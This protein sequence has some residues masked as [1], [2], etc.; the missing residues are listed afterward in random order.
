M[1]PV[2]TSAYDLPVRSYHHG[3][4]RAS[5]VEAGVQ[6][7]RASGPDGVVLREAARRTGVSH[8]AAY[9][10]FA[11]RK[12]LLS[13]I[14]TV[15]MQ[16]LGDAMRRE[17]DRV[18]GAEAR[19]R[20]VGRAYVAFAVDETGLFDVA[21]AAHPTPP[22]PGPVPGPEAPEAA[23][24]PYSLLNRVLDEGVAAGFVSPDR[25]P[26]ADITCWAGVHGFAVLHT[27]GPLAVLPPEERARGLEALLDTI[28]RGLR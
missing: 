1:W 11:D 25:R 24:D 9:R 10:H 8:N 3:N 17:L 7:A 5:L 6:L 12:D 23:L 2:S 19:L 15:A 22:E 20:A 13:E 26:G 4:L 28:A 14:A 27:H 18:E 16:R 21:F